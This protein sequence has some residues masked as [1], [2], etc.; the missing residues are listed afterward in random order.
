MSVCCFHGNLNAALFLPFQN[1]ILTFLNW[2]EKNE[3]L[4]TD[5]YF[6]RL[7]TA[8]HSF[9][10]GKNKKRSKV[11][12]FAAAQSTKCLLLF[13]PQHL[14][15]QLPIRSV[16]LVPLSHTCQS[17]WRAVNQPQAELTGI[18]RASTGVKEAGAEPSWS[19][20]TKANADV[21]VFL[22]AFYL[23]LP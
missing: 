8:L 4:L 6:S 21:Y 14:T 13:K 17:S 15:F 23:L 5:A 11:P 18:H 16:L 20:G 3:Y 2:R 12:P 19:A 9:N 1:Y 10:Q 22:S 7:I